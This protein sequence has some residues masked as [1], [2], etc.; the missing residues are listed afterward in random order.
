MKFFAITTLFAAVASASKLKYDPKYDASAS[1]SLSVV[2][3]SDGANGFLT[4][5]KNQVRNTQQL[6]TKLKPGV[7]LA[8][9]EAPWNSPK[10]GLCWKIVGAKSQRSAYFITID[11]STPAIVGGQD[12]FSALSPSKKTVEG[13]IDVWVYQRPASECYK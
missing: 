10:C 8:A 13:T 11:N 9:A 2:T 4:K 3:C 5:Y 12:L 7:Y 1:L 6:R